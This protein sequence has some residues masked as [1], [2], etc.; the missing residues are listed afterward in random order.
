MSL[1]QDKSAM[2]SLELAMLNKYKAQL[3]I[4]EYDLSKYFPAYC[5]HRLHDRTQLLHQLR[6]CDLAILYLKH[7]ELHCVTSPLP[8]SGANHV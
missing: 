3:A 8:D 4:M 1:K 6:V 2:G 5:A 7:P